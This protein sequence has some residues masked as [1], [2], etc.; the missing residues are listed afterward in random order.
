MEGA[1]YMIRNERSDWGSPGTSESSTSKSA[2]PAGRS[3]QAGLH[4]YQNF[5]RTTAG[6][7]SKHTLFTTTASGKKRQLREPYSNKTSAFSYLYHFSFSQS[8]EECVI[9]SLPKLIIY[10]NSSLFSSCLAVDNMPQAAN[11]S[12]PRD[13]TYSGKQTVS[14]SDNH[15]TPVMV[16]IS[17]PFKIHIQ[18]WHENES[19]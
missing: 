18:V 11:I 9:S 16:S 4:H 6:G 8:Y 14:K 1:V 5:I 12:S 2:L 17:A 3:A 7:R 10:I 15:G 19:G 13:D